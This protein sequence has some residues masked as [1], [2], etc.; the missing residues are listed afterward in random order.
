MK[1]Y[2]YTLLILV[3]FSCDKDEP[4]KPNT[5][6]QAFEVTAKV[7]G[8]DVTLTWTEAL[9]ADGDAVTYAVVYGAD[10]LTKGLTTRT[11][12]IKDL[13]YE[14]EIAGTVVAND[15]KGGKTES[16]FKV[17][18]P[19][20]VFVNI[21]DGEFEKYLISQKIDD[22]LDGKVLKEKLAS[23]T[24][25]DIGGAYHT[26]KDLTGVKAFI[27][28]EEIKVYQ[29][30][31]TTLDVSSFPKL[32]YLYVYSNQELKKVN[33]SNNT[34]LLNAHVFRNPKM[35]EADF[36]NNAVLEVV[37][38]YSNNLKKIMNLKSTKLFDL[39]V[40]DNPLLTDIDMSSLP[41]LYY[42]E[43]NS[44]SFLEL[45]FAKN[46]KL[47]TIDVYN[48]KTL[49]K[50]ILPKSSELSM[51]DI[52]GSSLS[53]INLSDAVALQYV[54]LV[55]NKLSSLDLSKNIKLKE[56]NLMQNKLESVEFS[57]LINLEKI[58]LTDNQLKKLDI[59]TCRKI[60]WLLCSQN[61]L[62]EICIPDG[63]I[64]NANWKKD[65]TATYKVCD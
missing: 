52:R 26:I 28:A 46:L 8:T 11:F 6:P 23:V 63:I 1:H 15:G 43:G 3:L 27:N 30:N 7:E 64:P 56:L 51:V 35:E 65:A 18:T 49:E 16:G 17:K 59:S 12:T 54:Y 13:P 20:S 4:E 19:E 45:N 44:A 48:N 2:L 29:T 55:G 38:C 5:S 32:K 21:P 9:D 50:V 37:E 14:T 58:D 61:S 25:V 41:E 36:L 62:T 22:V 33:L 24:K 42:F 47:R 40:T 39:M 10:T 31:I 57:P 53:S 60:K 34:R